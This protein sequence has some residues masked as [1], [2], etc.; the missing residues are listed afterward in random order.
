[1]ES[2][3]Y[4]TQTEADAKGLP[5]V[6]VQINRHNQAIRDL[7]GKGPATV[8]DALFSGKL[9]DPEATRTEHPPVDG[10]KLTAEQ[11]KALGF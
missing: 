6:Q 11:L 5:S 8:L 7:K 9:R 3:M 10:P 2:K 1:M 4:L